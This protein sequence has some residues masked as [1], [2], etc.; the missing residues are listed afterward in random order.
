MDDYGLSRGHIAKKVLS[1]RRMTME[2]YGRKARTTKYYQMRQ[3]LSNTA[4]GLP[5]YVAKAFLSNKN[6]FPDVL[7]GS[8]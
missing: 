1:S 2:D 6:A 3:R 5:D 8:K 7:L 4:V